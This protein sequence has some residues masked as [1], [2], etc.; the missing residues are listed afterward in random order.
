MVTLAAMRCNPII[1]AFAQ[2]LKAKGKRNKVVIVAAMRKLLSLL[3]V[4]ARDRLQWHELD[5]VKKLA[6][7]A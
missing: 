5:V 2:R 4:M 6:A 3:N 1:K 7:N